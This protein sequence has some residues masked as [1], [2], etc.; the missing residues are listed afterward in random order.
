M[1]GALTF[2]NRKEKHAYYKMVGTKDGLNEGQ[3]FDEMIINLL[4][5]KDRILFSRYV[6]TLESMVQSVFELTKA[7]AKT[8]SV[9]HAGVEINKKDVTSMKRQLIEYL[10]V[11]KKLYSI[12][13]SKPT[14]ASLTGVF[15][16]YQ[17]DDA[18]VNFVQNS[19]IVD[20]NGQ[21][22]VPY[23]TGTGLA[24][25]STLNKF[26]NYY[27]DQNRL[28][29]DVAGN[30]GAEEVLRQ[31]GI[32]LPPN[33]S[34]K[35]KAGGLFRADTALGPLVTGLAGYTVNGLVY[36]PFTAVSQIVLRNSRKIDD[37]SPDGK[38]FLAGYTGANAN[39][40]AAQQLH[41]DYENVYLLSE[42]VKREK[43]RVYS[44]NKAK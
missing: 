6:D 22:Y 1:E 8:D 14:P 37:K 2:K 24:H 21:S 33:V 13:R 12:K 44:Q 32:E 35:F 26:I 41:Q 10:R 23:L 5:S 28:K 27:I 3:K 11:A 43:R 18:L 30:G 31:A 39:S 15:R 42:G 9:T 20:E 40:V 19:G 29:I 36:Y 25:R 4:D 17:A 16:L 7:T 34:P 38:A